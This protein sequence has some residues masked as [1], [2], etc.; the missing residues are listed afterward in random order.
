MA[1]LVAA[2]LAEDEEVTEISIEQDEAERDAYFR[3]LLPVTPA[4]EPGSA[5]PSAAKEQADP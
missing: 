5:A 2:G 3:S 4:K 1:A